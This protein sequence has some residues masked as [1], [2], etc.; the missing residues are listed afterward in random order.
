[1]RI[2]EIEP[3]D[4]IRINR[5]REPVQVKLIHGS[6]VIVIHDDG[7]EQ[8]VHISQIYAF[9]DKKHK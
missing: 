1:M 8:S 5:N 4:I 3:G 2:N 7:S 9:W 6:R